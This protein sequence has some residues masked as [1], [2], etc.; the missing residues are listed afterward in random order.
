MY[1]FRKPLPTC[2]VLADDLIGAGGTISLGL[3]HHRGPGD[4]CAV[5]D[6][7]GPEAGTVGP[8]DNF[9][10]DPQ[11]REHSLVGLHLPSWK[12]RIR[13]PAS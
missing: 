1:S 8:S 12:R 9:D 4:P 10:L 7:A 5:V 11:A 2:A 13:R 3:G 6:S